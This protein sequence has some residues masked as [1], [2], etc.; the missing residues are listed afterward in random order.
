[1]NRKTNRSHS[2]TRSFMRDYLSASVSSILLLV[3]IVLIGF[4]TT[5]VYLTDLI[6]TT[7]HDLNEYAG[8]SLKI[9]GKQF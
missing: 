4:R 2:L 7:T 1:M 5:T 6:K 8:Q 9:L 3:L